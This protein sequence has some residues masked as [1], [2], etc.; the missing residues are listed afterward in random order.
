[1]SVRIV[2]ISFLARTTKT[3]GG[4]SGIMTESVGERRE[5]E[6]ILAKFKGDSFC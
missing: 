4:A 3:E 2:A 6:K 5:R 1:M